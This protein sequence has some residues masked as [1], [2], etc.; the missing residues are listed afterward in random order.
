MDDSDGDPRVSRR[1]LLRASAGAV[2]LST[3][4]TAEAAG[5]GTR[6]TLSGRCPDATIRPSMGHCAGA[7]TE[8]CADDHPATIELREA[9]ADILKDRYP[10]AGALLEAGFKPYFDTLDG[11]DGGYSHWLHP[12]YVGDD[13][14]LDPERPESV[15]VDDDSWRS[16][17]VMFIATRGDEPISPPAVYEA[18]DGGWDGPPED[19]YGEN[20][21]ADGY[22]DDHPSDDDHPHD[23][24]HPDG[25]SDRCSPWHYHAGAPGR[26]AWW[27]YRTVYEDAYRDGE[28]APP[29]RTPCMLHVWTV[30]HPEGVYAHDGPPPEYREREPPDD[31]GFETDSQPGEDELGWDVLPDEAVP[32]RLPESFS[33]AD[34]LGL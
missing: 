31:P 24:H 11:D 12:E 17:G 6:G 7:S 4:G 29:C 32:D 20:H 27:Y 5:E 33:L 9:V 23:D 18:G 13:A 28:L 3:V 14:V 22:G 26:L 15:L 34:G 30:D 10:D 1:G 19:D 8:G 16:I 2:A 25:D 21:D